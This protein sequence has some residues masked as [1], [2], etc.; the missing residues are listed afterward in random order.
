MATLVIGQGA[1]GKAVTENLSKQG[2]I[3]TAI[4][5]S[6]KSYDDSQIRFWQ[7]N[8]LDLTAN[9]LLA[10]DRIAIIITPNTTYHDTAHDR[11]IAYQDS[12]LA[13]AKHLASMADTLI[14]LRQL[15][16]VSSTSVYG[17]NNGNHVDEHTPITPATPTAHILHQAELTLQNAFGDKCTIVR[18]SGI[19]SINTKRMLRLAW[20]AHQDGVADKA[21]TNRIMQSDLINILVKILCLDSFKPAYLV[22]DT[23]PATSLEVLSFIANR[24]SYP[25]PKIIP[26]T[27]TGKKI[28]AN[29]PKDWLVFQNYQQGYDWIIQNRNT[30]Q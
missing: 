11:L 12:F 5:R 28:I 16:F 1:I 29:I 24:L 2:Q 18:P 30:T 4:A 8:A 3:V 21:W 25:P 27:P 15:V 19:Y 20:L 7:M 26:S 22:S 9:H 13:V 14:H 6:P 23:C 10:F 17:E